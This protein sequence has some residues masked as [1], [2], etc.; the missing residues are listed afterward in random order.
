MTDN[1]P[2]SVH[3]APLCRLP[4]LTD[5]PTRPANTTTCCAPS[6]YGAFAGGA[7]AS[8]SSTST[9]SA[10]TKHKKMS[11]STH[12]MCHAATSHSHSLH[13]LL[14]SSSFVG[15]GLQNKRVQ[16]SHDHARRRM[17]LVLSNQGNI[18]CP[19]QRLTRAERS[20]AAPTRQLNALPTTRRRPHG[21]RIFQGYVT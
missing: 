20:T 14:D 4:T 7:S 9:S 6:S 3:T 18:S 19:Q 2:T 5:G 12:R 1:H 8:S 21:M 15:C 10:L 13:S 17:A 11:A 16:R